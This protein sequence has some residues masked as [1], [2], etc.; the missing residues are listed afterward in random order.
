MVPGVGWRTLKAHRHA[1]S[2]LARKRTSFYS[3]ISLKKV[4]LRETKSLVQDHTACKRPAVIVKFLRGGIKKQKE[5]L[6]YIE[7]NW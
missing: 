4:G 6:F 3:H 7:L 1:A 5:M 2:C